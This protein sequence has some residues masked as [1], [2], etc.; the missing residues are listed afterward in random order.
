MYQLQT[1]PYLSQLPSWPQEGKP[2]LAQF[3]TTTAVVYQAYRPAIGQFAA[4]HGYFGG[5]FS[6]Q[7]MSWIKPGF[8]W[9]MYRSGW[10]TKP[11]QHCILAIWLKRAAFECMLE[12]A[13][14]T[15][16]QP[17]RYASL[18]AWQQAGADASVRLQWDPDHDPTGKPVQ[19]R[20]LQLGLR[21]P[22]LARYAREWI[23]HIED[24]SDFVQQQR[25]NAVPE[26]YASLLLPKES[27]YPVHDSHL[28]EK[29]GIE[30]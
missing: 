22:V 16:F 24:I 1:A 7:R 27:V 29:L 20:A 25:A 9:M 2:I 17:G 11:D 30:V 26:R 13:V 23:V 10:G 21:G 15:T 19:R 8:L 5:D 3:D 6:F 14:P 12:E 28:G 18:A 4:A